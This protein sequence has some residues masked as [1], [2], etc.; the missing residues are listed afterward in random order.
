MR[1]DHVDMIHTITDGSLQVIH[2]QS[3]SCFSLNINVSGLYHENLSEFQ[4][5]LRRGYGF[6]V[7]PPRCLS[8][9]VL[10]EWDMYSK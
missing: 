1:F 8:L 4:S 9:K 10:C 7:R 5:E 2:T 3:S 6:K